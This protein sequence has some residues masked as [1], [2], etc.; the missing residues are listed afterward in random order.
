MYTK[1]AT[2]RHKNIQKW[3]LRG[4]EPLSTER[5]THTQT[6]IKNLARKYRNRDTWERGDADLQ[7][8]IKRLLE[9]EKSWKYQ[10]DSEMLS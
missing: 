10:Q 3:K 9:G 1:N 8:Q 7:K 6:K 2:Q 5:K 4:N